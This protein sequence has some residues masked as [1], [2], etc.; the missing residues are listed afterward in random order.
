MV[1]TSASVSSVST[2]T[3]PAAHAQDALD[4]MMKY[5]KAVKSIIQPI[6]DIYQKLSS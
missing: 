6:S 4:R 1:G 5:G 3:F 2:S